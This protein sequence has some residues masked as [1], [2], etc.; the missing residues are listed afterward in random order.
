LYGL[1]HFE[2]G[3]RHQQRYRQRDCAFDECS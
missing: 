3:E 1:D 2:A